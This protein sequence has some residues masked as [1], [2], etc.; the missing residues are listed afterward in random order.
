MEFSIPLGIPMARILLILEKS[1]FNL[2]SPLILMIWPG[3]CKSTR[4]TTAENILDKSVASAAPKTP[5]LNPKINRAFPATL[6]MF[7][8]MATFIGSLVFPSAL[9]IAPPAAASAIPG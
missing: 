4:S 3:L 9:K 2:A 5:M 7:E 6:S 1:G 8:T